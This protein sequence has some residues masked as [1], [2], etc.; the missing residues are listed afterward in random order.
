M[1]LLDSSFQTSYSKEHFPGSDFRMVKLMVS[2]HRTSTNAGDEPVLLYSLMDRRCRRY[3][4]Y[5]RRHRYYLLSLTWRFREC[6]D[7]SSGR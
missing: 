5:W 3:Y 6:F 2:C 1:Y 4:H 7:L